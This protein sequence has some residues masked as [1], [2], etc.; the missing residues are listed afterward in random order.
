MSEEGRTFVE[1][2]LTMPGPGLTFVEESPALFEIDRTLSEERRSFSGNV[3][4]CPRWVAPCFKE[5][6]LPPPGA[7]LGWHSCQVPKFPL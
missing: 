1:K 2:G 5:G 6:R 7:R 4:L 3:E